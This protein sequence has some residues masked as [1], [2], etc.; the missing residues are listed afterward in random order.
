MQACTDMYPC[1]ALVTTQALVQLSNARTPMLCDLKFGT[2]ACG[3][4]LCW[5][6][7]GGAGLCHAVWRRLQAEL[8]CAVWC[9]QKQLDTEHY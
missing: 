9:I 3:A 7:R 2:I 4:V 6:G 5:A 8:G 1:L